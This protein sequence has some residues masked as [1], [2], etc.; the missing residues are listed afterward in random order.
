M[1]T[2]AELAHGVVDHRAAVGGVRQVAGHQGAA[3]PGRLDQAGGFARVLV[4]LGVEV[5]DQDVGAFAGIG[6]GDRPADAAVA[7]RDHRRAAGELARAL[8]AGLAVIGGNGQLGLGSGGC[9]WGD[10][11]MAR[12]LSALSSRGSRGEFLCRRPDD[13][14][15]MRWW[16]PA[17]ATEG[18]PRRRVALD[19]TEREP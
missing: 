17:A 18:G 13:A 7:P 16:R 15:V 14:A 12:L 9:W 1:S 2:P 19:G 11:G 6:D 8:V 4:L 5:A 10:S 3:A